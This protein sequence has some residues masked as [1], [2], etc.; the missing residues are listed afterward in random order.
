MKSLAL[1]LL[2]SFGASP[3]QTF[4][5]DASGGAGSSFTS[6]AIAAATVPS[7][8]V[9]QVVAGVY[10][11]FVVSGKSLTILGQQGVVVVG[12][13]FGP[14][15]VLV[16][17]TT[18][19]QVVTI[20]DVRL[21]SS[22][23]GPL[24]IDCS[25]CF[26][27]VLLEDIALDASFYTGIRKLL[28]VQNC[29]QLAMT[30]CGPFFE[31]PAGTRAAIEISASDVVLRECPT[32]AVLGCCLRATSATV[33]LVD[34]LYTNAGAL[35]TVD[36]L[37]SSLRVLGTSRLE[38][39][40]PLSLFLVLGGNGSVVADPSVTLI[41]NV[42]PGVA[43]V[44]A[45][46]ALVRA[47]GGQLGSVTLATMDGPAGQLG[48][49]FLGSLGPRQSVPGMGN[50]TWIAPGSFAA[51]PIGVFG[52]QLTASVPVPNVPGLLG[53]VFVWQGVAFGATAGF[54]LSNPALF[55]P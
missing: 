50:Q 1:C 29:A 46:Q 23:G 11:P 54:S 24:G 36:L 9:L 40:V 32:D 30:R 39:A 18:A 42:T 20:R 14:G 41:G 21:R 51:G 6:I 15:N 55:T 28:T 17:N 16:Q 19:T 26:G 5:V 53:Q 35:P 33:Q 38:S 45:P 31:Q 13:P 8:A 7:G 44:I 48:A 52:P 25:N 34:A 27:P 49:L 12:P 3:A 4:I 37:G 47:S 22:F 10:D 2:L 43:L